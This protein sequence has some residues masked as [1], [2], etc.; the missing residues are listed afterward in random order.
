M[1]CGKGRYGSCVCD[2]VQQILDAQEAVEDRCPTSC[3]ENLLSPANTLGDTVPFVLTGKKGEL[4]KA[5][6]NV[7]GFSDDNLCFET[8][9]FR[10]EKLRGCCATLSLLRAYD[11]TG[12]TINVCSPCDRDLYG[13]ER[14]NFCMEVDLD[15]FCAI[16]CLTPQLVDRALDVQQRRKHHH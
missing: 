6:G 8:I 15:C 5:F 7:G 16:Q 11:S 12:D 9:F 2:A 1:S 4:F 14:T 3:F 13:L 10:V